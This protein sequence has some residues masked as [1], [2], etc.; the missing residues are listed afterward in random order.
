MYPSVT[1]EQIDKLIADWQR[2]VA[3]AT[4]NLLALDDTPVMQR[5]TG[6]EGIAAQPL[7]GVTAAR[8]LPALAAMRDLFG[9]LGTIGDVVE[10]ASRMRRAANRLWRYDEAMTAIEKLL[11]GPSIPLPDLKTPL[12]ERNL[13]SSSASARAV[14]PERLLTAMTD[15]FATARDAVLAVD[16][17]WERWE[18][19]QDAFHEK[20]VTLSEQCES[21]GLPP[22]PQLIA[23]RGGIA[24]LGRRVKSDPLGITASVERDLSLSLTAAR[25]AI[26][27]ERSEREAVA[28]GLLAARQ[29][30]T[31][32]AAEEAAVADSCAA[33]AAA[34]EM[35]GGDAA[36]QPGAGVARLQE[37]EGWLVSLEGSAR[38][39]R[40]QAV[41][42]GLGRWTQ[43]A[44]ALRAS[45]ASA[46]KTNQALVEMPAELRGRHAVLL[47]R[48]RALGT[49]DPTLTRLALQARTLLDEP[50]VPLERATKLIEVCEERLRRESGARMEMH[51]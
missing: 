7:T 31:S 6:G 13:L 10:R 37:L 19:I 38:E 3:A 50:R 48:M 15:A 51:Q 45:L 29:L 36:A 34:L 12:A 1:Q 33:C 23:A 16:A 43:G 28:T 21:L 24:D 5:I 14:T 27:S 44:N 11:T 32:I 8:V 35:E 40:W 30:L 17:A 25:T 18:P 20:E 9:Q 26:E 46:R 4:E 49:S 42:V 2:K 41:A 22:P 47:A 39:K